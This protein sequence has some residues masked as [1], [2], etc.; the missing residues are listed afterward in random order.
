MQSGSQATLSSAE[1][2]ETLRSVESTVSREAGDVRATRESGGVEVGFVPSRLK[3][4]LD[5]HDHLNRPGI[6][7]DS[8]L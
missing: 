8:N 4:A 3:S 5:E 2:G 1:H 6:T 7:G